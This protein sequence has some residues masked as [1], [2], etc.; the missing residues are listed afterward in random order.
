MWTKAFWKAIAERAIK[1]FAEAL[2]AALVINQLTPANI[3]WIASFHIAGV[4]ALI[5]VL[6]NIGTAKATDGSPS[7]ADEKLTR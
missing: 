6:L 5:A 4:A 1:T 2:A 7:L 3:D